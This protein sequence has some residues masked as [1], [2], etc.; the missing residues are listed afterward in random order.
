[1]PLLLW[2][3]AKLIK[4]GIELFSLQLAIIIKMVYNKYV[5][6]HL[7]AGQYFILLKKKK[8]KKK[9]FN[10]VRLSLLNNNHVSLTNYVFQKT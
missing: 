3:K 6:K 2:V 8:K 1:M 5:Y 4:Y 10:E 9:K 7:S